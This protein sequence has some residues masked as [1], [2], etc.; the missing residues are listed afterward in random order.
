MYVTTG[1]LCYGCDVFRC[2]GMLCNS[3]F[4][5]VYNRGYTIL[6]HA[7]MAM[8]ILCISSLDQVEPITTPSTDE[9]VAPSTNYPAT[10]V[11]RATLDQAEPL[12]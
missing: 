9:G 7:N 10:A 2:M 12:Q 3:N 5:C 1:G 8:Y 4:D 11:S 6:F